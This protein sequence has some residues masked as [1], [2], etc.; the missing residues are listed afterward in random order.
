MI[1]ALMASS[2]RRKV[3]PDGLLEPWI[4]EWQLEQARFGSRWSPLAIR[5]EL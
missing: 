3:L 1:R 4:W 5:W 2:Y